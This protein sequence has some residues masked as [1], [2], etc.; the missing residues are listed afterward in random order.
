VQGGFGSDSFGQFR[1]VSTRAN[2]MPAVACYVRK[3]GD[4]QYLPAA[5]DVLVIEEGLVKEITTFPLDS[6]VRAF[7]LPTEL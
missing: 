7:G 6:L 1:C 2:R 5:L 3:P 4:G